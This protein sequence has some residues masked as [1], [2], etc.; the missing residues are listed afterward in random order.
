MNSQVEPRTRSEVFNFFPFFSRQSESTSDE[1][2]IGGR[3][4]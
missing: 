2:E 3:E 1:I 4:L